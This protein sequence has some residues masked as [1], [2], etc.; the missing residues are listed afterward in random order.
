MRRQAKTC[1]LMTLYQKVRCITTF[2]KIN[3]LDLSISFFFVF[4]GCIHALMHGLIK[5]LC[6]SLHMPAYVCVT[7]CISRV[8]VS[9]WGVEGGGGVGELGGVKK[10]Q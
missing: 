2:Y 3:K 5:Y 4:E 1:F 7:M 6:Y 10:N 9:N 8:S